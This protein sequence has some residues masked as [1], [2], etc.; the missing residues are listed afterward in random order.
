VAV[1][2]LLA[3]L[4]GLFVGIG[5]FTFGYAKGAS[6]MFDDPEACA[7]CHVMNEQ[8]DSWMKGSHRRAAVCND[9]H[10]P[11]GFIPKYGTK[12]LN[13]FF[14]SWAFTTGR[15]PDRIR[16]TQR[17]YDVANAACM[18]CHAEITSGMRSARGHDGTVSCIQCH[19]QAGHM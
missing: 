3:V 4:V 9:C 1:P 8:F 12:A 7:N 6:Y 2:V 14:H 16:I 5:L 10:T 13:G 15:F 18:K 19:Q 11:A 17:N